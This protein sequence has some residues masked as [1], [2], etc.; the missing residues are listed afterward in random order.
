VPRISLAG[1]DEASRGAAAAA[2]RRLFHPDPGG[3]TAQPAVADARDGVCAVPALVGCSTGAAVQLASGRPVAHADTAAAGRTATAAPV[4]PLVTSSGA[5]CHPRAVPG[6]VLPD[7]ACTPGTANPDVTQA[8]IG[9]T[10]CRAGYTAT[11][12]PPASYT[13]ALKRQQI[14]AYGGSPRTGRPPPADPSRLRP[15]TN[16]DDLAPG[17]SND[18]LRSGC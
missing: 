16:D 8:T 15:A 7:A 14:V 18:R 6:G 10:I 12:R 13:D 3:R 1:T 4:P 9:S 2:P 17:P 11:I 5:L